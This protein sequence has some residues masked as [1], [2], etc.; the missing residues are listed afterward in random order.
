[1]PELDYYDVLRLEKGRDFGEAVFVRVAAGRSPADGFVDDCCA[2]EI[3]FEVRPPAWIV[4]LVG[5]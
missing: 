2:R 5:A 1:V 4:S 3:G